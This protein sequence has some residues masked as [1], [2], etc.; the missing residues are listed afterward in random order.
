MV[1][2]MNYS[3]QR[4]TILDTLR[5]YTVHPSAEQLYEKVHSK[6]KT[7]SKGT[8]YRNL[9]QLAASGI[10]KKIDGLDTS[11]HFDHNTHEHYHFICNRC[12]KIYDIEKEDVKIPEIKQKDEFIITNHD[13]IFKGICKECRKKN[14]D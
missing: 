4:E 7:I 2:S 9:N 3:K 1:K 5:E 12:K 11:A 14:L 13:I 6:D 10:I 8:L